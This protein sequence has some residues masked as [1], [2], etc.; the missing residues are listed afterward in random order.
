[1]P[2]LPEVETIVKDLDKIVRGLRITNIWTDWPKMVKKPSY[3]EFIKQIKNR[4]ILKARRRAKYI[5]INLSKNKTL[6]IHQ[7]IS[8][9]LLYGSWAVKGKEIK[10]LSNGPLKDDPQNRFIRLIFYLNNGKQLGLSDLRRF[11]KVLLIDTDK[12]NNLQE[13]KEL[14]PE[15]LDKKFTFKKFKEILQNKRGKTKQALMSQNVIAGIGNIYSDEILFEARIHPLK[16]IQDLK[17]DDLKRIYNSIK[18][19]LRRAIILRGDSMSDYRDVKGRKGRYQE[20]Q[21]VYQRKGQKCYRCRG[22]IKR[23]K[24]GGRSAHYCPVCQK[25]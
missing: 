14:G 22:T 13:I 15:P 4:K 19:I 25:L 18:K 23:I 21:K 9:H 2:E 12:V 8:G 10:S 11:A 5:L 1:M 16:Q 20:V 6:I 3:S 24:T 17:D 7:K